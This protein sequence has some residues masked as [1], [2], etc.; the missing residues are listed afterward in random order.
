M[1]TAPPLTLQLTLDSL[2]ALARDHGADLLT[3]IS[4]A[5][6]GAMLTVHWT[7]EETTKECT[8]LF[9]AT[10]EEPDTFLFGFVVAAELWLHLIE[11]GVTSPEADDAAR[12]MVE[13][14]EAV[15]SYLV[16]LPYEWIKTKEMAS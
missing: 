16:G 2:T 9:G 7:Q 12:R 10:G 14:Y 6:S 4:L 5:H 15:V 8:L 3:T 1:T 13:S 11:E